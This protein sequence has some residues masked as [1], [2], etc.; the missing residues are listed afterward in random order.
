MKHQTIITNTA[1]E[2]EFA[3][4]F[5]D[6]SFLESE[7][8]NQVRAMIANPALKHTRVMPDCHVG[9]GCCVGFTA[10]TDCTMVVP[11]YVGGDIGCGILTYPTQKT[12]LNLQKIETR[13]KSTIPMG[14]GH[15]HIHKEN[16]VAPSY[17]DKHLVVA[18]AEVSSLVSRLDATISAPTINYDYFV[19]LCDKIGMD[20]STCIRSF[21]TLG[22]GNHFIE[23]N[24]ESRTSEYYLTVHSGSRAFGMKLFEYHNAKVDKTLKHLN[25][26]DSLEYC[27]D[28]IVAQHLARMNRH[29]MLQ[30]ILRE[31]DL[32]Y[33]ETRL[34]ESTHNYIDFSRGILRKGAIPAELG[35]LCIVALNMRDGILICRGKGN[36]DWNYSC[37]HGC[38]RHMSRSEARRRIK[39]KDYKK[40]MHDVV[41]SSVCEATLDEAPQAYKDVDLVVAALEP[42]VTIEKHL[43]SVLNLKGTD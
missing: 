32:D 23:I 31:L 33:D 6:E 15:A 3:K 24:Q 30:L 42:T 40:V 12:K 22:G 17:I 16:P 25:T 11:S 4:V 8:T 39:L 37:A 34:I 38:G 19:Q 41:S 26:A 21:G 1:N 10:C 9:H 28:M 5:L 14:N 29:I 43:I 20:A 2:A 13:I 7:T 36:E 18:E 27:I 35:E